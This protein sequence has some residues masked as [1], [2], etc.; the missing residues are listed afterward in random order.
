M[1]KFAYNN[2]KHASIGYMLFELNYKYHSCVSYKEDIDSRSMSK[3]ADELTEELGN[4]IAA[5]REK[6]QH[7]QVLQ[8]QAHNK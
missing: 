2:I 5:C 1:A 4:L 6:L 7:A 3:V 8:K